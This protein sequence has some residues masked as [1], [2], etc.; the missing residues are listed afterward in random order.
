MPIMVNFVL[1]ENLKKKK[2]NLFKHIFFGSLF[3]EEF[4]FYKNKIK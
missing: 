4:Y 3:T 1:K 2:K